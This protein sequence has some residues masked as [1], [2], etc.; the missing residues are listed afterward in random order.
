MSV[1][2]VRKTRIL[3]GKIL[4][5]TWKYVSS[6]W[7]RGDFV[8]PLFF[9]QTLNFSCLALPLLRLPECFFGFS[10]CLVFEP[11]FIWCVRSSMK[12][13]VLPLLLTGKPHSNTSFH[14]MRFRRIGIRFRELCAFVNKVGALFNSAMHL[15]CSPWVLTHQLCT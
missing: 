7:R 10:V 1:C 5:W 14:I 8:G 4:Q 6:S 11:S 9:P 2:A 13:C 15:C 3:E 12:T